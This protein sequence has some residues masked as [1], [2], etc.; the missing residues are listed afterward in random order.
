M[1]VVTSVWILPAWASSRGDEGHAA[2]GLEG[3][4][5]GR[6]VGIDP[7]QQRRHRRQFVHVCPVDQHP[8][9]PR[10]GDQMDGVVGRT[11]G[12]QKG[13]DHVDD[14]LLVDDV[15]HA[16]LAAAG[17]FDRPLRRRCRQGVAQAGVGMDE[18]GGGHM[19]PAQLHHHLVGVGGAVEGAGAGRV[20]AADLAFQQ[21]LTIDLVLGIFGADPG[22]SPHSECPTAWGRPGRRRTGRWPKARAP[23]NRPGTILSQTPSISPA[24]KASWVRATPAD[25]AMTSAAEQRQLHAGAALGHAVAHGGGAAGDLG[26]GADLAHGLSHHVGET[27]ERLVGRQHV[28]IGGDDAQVRLGPVH[29][30]QLVGDGLAREGVGPVG[31]GQFGAAGPAVAGGVHATDIVGAGLAGFSRQCGR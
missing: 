29:R 15:G 19:Q 25:M 1:M 5:I 3:V 31:A 16:A 7:R 14:G 8:R 6:A 18:G 26:R 30:R 17:Q 27:F 22:L 21:G 4:H 24:S 13:H 9:R 10:H 28:V 2:G 23:M 20:I 12:G 11:P